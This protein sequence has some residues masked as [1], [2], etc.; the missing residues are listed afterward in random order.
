MT[1]T[2]TLSLVGKTRVEVRADVFNLFNAENYTADGYIGILGNV[3]YGKPTSGAYPGRQ[4]QFG[5]IY[6]F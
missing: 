5:A 4:F 1:L 3:N 6:R 2:R